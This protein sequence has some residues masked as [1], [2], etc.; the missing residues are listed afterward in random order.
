MRQI[1][2]DEKEKRKTVLFFPIKSVGE[3]KHSKSEIK[4]IDREIAIETALFQNAEDTNARADCHQR[5][6]GRATATR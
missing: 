3:H 5:Q 2:G 4:R 6:C 1:D